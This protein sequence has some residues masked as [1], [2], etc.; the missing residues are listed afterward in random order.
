MQYYPRHIEAIVKRVKKQFPV[1]LITGP[2]QVG[3]S[4]LLRHISS[5]KYEEVSFDDP[6][7]RLQAE[8]DPNLFVKNN[9]P[10][11]MLDEIQ[12]VPGIFPYLKMSIDK[13]RKDGD[14]LITGSQAFVLMKNVSE[15][16]AGRVAVLELQGVSQRETNNCDFDMPFIPTDDYISKRANK[17]TSYE[18]IWH[19]IHRGYMPELVYNPEKDW[20]VFYSSYVQTYIERDVRQL[21]QVADEA[22][23]LKFMIAIA[24]R[25]G[26]LIN[27]DSV[28]RDVGVS[29]DTI[30][31]WLSILQTSR[32]IYLLEPY[33]NN[34][35]KRSIKTPKVYFLDT[36][37]LAY[38]TRWPTP[39][40]L[41]NGAK[42]GNVFETFVISE[43][44]KSYINA[45]KINLP[46]Y[47]YRDR[48]GREIDLVIESA[49]TLYPIEIKMTASPNI[50]MAKI[51]SALDD[52]PD[53]KRGTGV[54]L[55]QYDRKHMLSEQVV[56]LPIEYI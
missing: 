28:A 16:L 15:S 31:R 18:N 56:A 29:S 5:G 9:P 24:A 53:K 34:Q 19:S 39:E 10:P 46:L 26:E 13:D 27:Y 4:T 52:V 30:K 50:S 20:E 7:I 33:H 14:Y 21:T 8:N 1:T 42:A 17:I 40:T 12:Y 48:D 25:S 36:G 32:I 55:C 38:L 11:I 37:L 43:I 3:K 44:I 54:I 41:A 22:L 47:F 6:I 35:L 49:D 2:R 45:G 23:F 51:F